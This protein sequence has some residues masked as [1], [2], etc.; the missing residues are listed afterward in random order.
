MKHLDDLALQKA[1]EETPEIMEDSLAKADR[2]FEFFKNKE[3][4][5]MQTYEFANS[6]DFFVYK[7][8]KVFGMNPTD[9]TAL[10]KAIR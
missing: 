3:A 6:E 2:I 7:L 4:E 1:I 9:A 8:G 5:I 10:F